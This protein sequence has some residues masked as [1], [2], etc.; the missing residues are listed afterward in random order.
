MNQKSL[1]LTLFSTAQHVFMFVRP[2][3]EGNLAGTSLI[4]LIPRIV[5]LRVLSLSFNE[6][7]LVGEVSHHLF[8]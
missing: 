2:I 1:S 3:R 4:H 8:L 7:L 6:R 5:A